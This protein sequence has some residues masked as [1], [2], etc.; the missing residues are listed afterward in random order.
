MPVCKVYLL[1][2]VSLYFFFV[3]VVVVFFCQWKRHHIFYFVHLQN[4]EKKKSSY[5]M[6]P[7]PIAFPGTVCTSGQKLIVSCLL[8]AVSVR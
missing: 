5:N 1:Q 3:A 2:S 8:L 7:Y 4:M 6:K